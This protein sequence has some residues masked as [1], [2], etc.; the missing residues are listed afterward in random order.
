VVA[1]LKGSSQSIPKP[2]PG[3]ETKKFDTNTGIIK[4]LHPKKYPFSVL[5]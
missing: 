3:H 2:A 5:L 4:I 1:E